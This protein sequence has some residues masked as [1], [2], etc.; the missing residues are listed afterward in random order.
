MKKEIITKLVWLL[1]ILSTYT[2]L[3]CGVIK[4]KTLHICTHVVYPRLKSNY[5]LPKALLTSDY[6]QLLKDKLSSNVCIN[7]D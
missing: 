2:K 4:K 5:F 3:S 7:L 6:V 1:Y